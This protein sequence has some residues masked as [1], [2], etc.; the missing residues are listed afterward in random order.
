MPTSGPRLGSGRRALR[1]RASKGVHR[2]L[3]HRRPSPGG[4]LSEACQ[5]VAPEGS[6]TIHAAHGVQRG[7]TD[8]EC[9]RKMT[10]P[11]ARWRFRGSRSRR[12][13]WSLE[14]EASSLPSKAAVRPARHSYSGRVEPPRS[15]SRARDASRKRRS[16]LLKEGSRL[17]GRGSRP[18]TWSAGTLGGFRRP[19]TRPGLG[20]APRSTR[21]L[22]AEE[23][24]LSAEGRRYGAAATTGA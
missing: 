1:G 15:P 4:A 23:S 22:S 18:F 12:D 21:A 16:T 17:I 2:R 8:S 11:G 6:W 9:A 3:L 13:G 7:K 10:V 5:V 14:L 24:A 20:V 19:I